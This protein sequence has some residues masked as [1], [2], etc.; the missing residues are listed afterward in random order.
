MPDL[1][2]DHVAAVAAALGLSIADDDL[3]EVVHRL[4]GFLDAFE[5]LGAVAGD[6][7]DVP[8]PIPV[9]PAA[10]PGRGPAPAATPP[11]VTPPAGAADLAHLPAA[12]Q[13]ELLRARALSPVDLVRAYLERIERL[14]GRLRS[15][16]TV[17]ADEALAEAR[18]AEAEQA[19]GAW[20]GP[21]HGIPFAVKDQF[22]TAG[23]RTTA[24]SR[25]FA[26]RVP[27]ADA[28]VVARLREG[29]AILLGKLNLSELAMGDTVEFPFGQP[30]NPW[31]L[32]HHP[33]SSSGGSGAATAAGLCAFSLGEDTA[34]SIR[35]PAAYCG[36][37]GLRPT[38]GRLSRAGCMP[39]AWSLDAPG[40]ITRTVE[41]CAI[42]YEATAGH[43]PADVTS[44]REPVAPCRPGLDAGVRGLRLGVVRE[45][46]ESPDTDAEVRDAV[47]A[48][49]RALA[50]AGATVDEVSLPLAPLA[51]A[52]SMALAD[53]E[54]AGLYREALR[55][56]PRDLD[57]NTRRRLLAASLLPAALH[58]R[59]RQAR[60]AVRAEVAAALA[61]VDVLLAPASPRPAPRI[62]D[63]AAPITSK[64]AAA[65]RFFIRRAYNTPASLAGLPAL[66]VP[67]GLSAA[68]LPIGLQA[69]GRALD[70][71][72]LL[73]VARAVEQACGWPRRP[74]FDG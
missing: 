44:R 39:L 40:P 15:Y 31:S 6:G 23:L 71:A 18:G 54:G 34:G 69:I 5:T 1:A 60:A 9:A 50:G 66:S 49:A 2:P 48:A 52:V 37:V 56:R 61:R 24:G 3:P 53:A 41:D 63:G 51:G 46:V 14:D 21:L 47:A 36:L 22:D 64:A 43:D 13:A 70:E 67:C 25:L 59:A 30:R 7:P 4:N 73:R 58:H 38:W 45:L 35:G 29:G 74:P 16:I 19:R 55:A 42:V 65:G 32:E 11:A 33:G 28:T 27:A 20:R 68:G 10:A 62:A 17:R 26:D 12:R 72:T 8:W 57:R